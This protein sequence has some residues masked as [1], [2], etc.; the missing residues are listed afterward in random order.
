MTEEV[1][2]Q[3]LVMYIKNYIPA[4]NGYLNKSERES[5]LNLF[6]EGINNYLASS[7]EVFNRYSLNL[8]TPAL[9]LKM[10]NEIINY[11]IN[12]L[13]NK[14]RRFKPPKEFYEADIDIDKIC[15]I[16]GIESK[17]IKLL[18]RVDKLIRKLN[19]I[20]YNFGELRINLEMILEGAKKLDSLV[21]EWINILNKIV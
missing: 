16:M 17:I 15:K 5:S 2:C 13:I 4:Y 8:S 11:R 1:S 21:D 12:Y 19:L 20:G 18:D 3:E 9:D 10:F 6:K 14:I 7:S